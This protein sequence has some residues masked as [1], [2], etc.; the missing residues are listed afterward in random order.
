MGYITSYEAFVNHIRNETFGFFW[1]NIDARYSKGG[2]KHRYRYASTF[3][4]GY[5]AV[6]QK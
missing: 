1:F 6:I 5:P 3:L 2:V 4:G